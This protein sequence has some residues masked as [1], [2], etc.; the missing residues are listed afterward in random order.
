MGDRTRRRVE[1]SHRHTMTYFPESPSQER[2]ERPIFLALVILSHAVAQLQI[3][4]V[5][6]VN[7]HTRNLFHLPGSNFSPIC[8]VEVASLV[9]TLASAAAV[10]LFCHELFR[11]RDLSTCSPPTTTHLPLWTSHA[12]TQ[13]CLSQKLT[14]WI[15]S[16]TTSKPSIILFAHSGQQQ[17]PSPAKPNDG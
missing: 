7:F 17:L 16:T 6:L 9:N 5:T 12:A 8:K 1:H 3:G 13:Q 11:D 10:L 15:L 14:S 4:I 2:A